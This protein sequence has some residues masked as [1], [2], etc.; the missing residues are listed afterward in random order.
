MVEIWGDFDDEI[1][2]K[3]YAEKYLDAYAGKL[4]QERETWR[5]A[6][7]RF[8]GTPNY[9]LLTKEWAPADIQAANS[10]QNFAKLEELLLKNLELTI[11][12]NFEHAILD[13]KDLLAALLAY[14]IIDINVVRRIGNQSRN[15]CS[16][17]RNAIAR[18]V[19]HSAFVFSPSLNLDYSAKVNNIAKSAM[20]AVGDAREKMS[21][22]LNIEDLKKMIVI[23][24]LAYISQKDYIEQYFI[25]AFNAAK[26]ALTPDPNSNMTKNDILAMWAQDTWDKPE[27]T[28]NP[29]IGTFQ[30]IALRLASFVNNYPRLV[31]LAG[32]KKDG[33]KPIICIGVGMF[34]VQLW[35][36]VL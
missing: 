19:V 36:K 3:D 7:S 32:L 27:L 9:I 14:Y 28:R 29:Y 25:P 31:F 20:K 30:R 18:A 12:A 11:I 17:A 16:V 5:V 10:D 35:K 2:W 26:E 8:I 21:E 22:I 1:F 24:I 23:F 13:S 6:I 34:S 4:I 33:P 15:A